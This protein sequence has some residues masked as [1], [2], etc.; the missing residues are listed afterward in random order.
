MH[1]KRY[2]SSINVKAFFL[3]I[4]YGCTPNDHYLRQAP[5]SERKG[6]AIVNFRNTT[7]VTAGKE[8]EPWQYGIPAML[9]TDLESIGLFNIVS[10]ERL[11]E[12]LAEQAF[13]ASGLVDKQTIVKMGKLVAAHYI[14]T[15]S[16]SVMNDRMRIET[17]VFSV[18]NGAQLGAAE[19][20]GAPEAFFEL[21]KQMV[22]K[23]SNYL[24]AMLTEEDK[25]RIS[26]N[27]ETKSIQASL[28]NYA[29]EMVL[30]LVKKLR[31][32]GKTQ[33]AEQA[34]KSAAN[35]FNQAL[36]FDPAYERAKANLRKLMMG[37]PVTL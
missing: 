14:L 30:D 15:G 21:E 23:I 2:R 22:F 18:E 6:L 28:N 36:D 26:K 16:Y 20:T 33:E 7:P 1:V 32:L 10:K 12:I 9:M 5:R 24:Q 19:V 11:K 3:C 8:Y 34:E 31:D 35:K 29:G 37:L 13:Q 4:I 25:I 17:H 27:I